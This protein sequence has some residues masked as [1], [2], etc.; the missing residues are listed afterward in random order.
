MERNT[1]LPSLHARLTTHSARIAVVGLGYV[2]IATVGQLLSEGHRVFAFE[3]DAE[4]RKKLTVGPW[5]FPDDAGELFSLVTSAMLEGRL[6]IHEAPLD[7]QSFDVCVLCTETPAPLGQFDSEPLRAAL[8]LA[9]GAIPELLV[10]QSTLPAGTMEG[11]VSSV[12]GDCSGLLVYAPVRVMPGRLLENTRA[13][14]RVVGVAEAQRAPATLAMCALFASTAAHLD[15]VDFTTAEL[16]KLAENAYRDA[17]IALANE[18]ALL[19]GDAGG[20]FW[21]VRE[22]VNAVPGRALALPGPGVGGACLPKDTWLLLGSGER[23]SSSRPSLLEAARAIN[24]SMPEH[25]AQALVRALP[26]AGEHAEIAVLG[27]T[28]RENCAVTRD[29]PA[30]AVIELLTKQCEGATLRVHDPKAAPG[31]LPSV[32]RGA[33]AVLVLVRH[34]AYRGLDWQAL[35]K[36]M[37]GQL[38]FDACGVVSADDLAGTDLVLA[39]LGRGA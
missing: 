4:Q 37:R 12:F 16:V 34:D 15:F 13:L 32:V 31:D 7:N 23:S 39:G 38:V 9:R 27:V 24:L 17:Q 36:E 19:C 20:D 2:G 6:T 11:L 5:P 30:Q 26:F 35:A 18:I 25:I 29:S 1:P 33:D 8:E 28:Y 21:R 22:L 10:V 3:R 14:R